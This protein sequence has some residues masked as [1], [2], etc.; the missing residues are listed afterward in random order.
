LRNLLKLLLIESIC[1]LITSRCRYR[2]NTCIYYRCSTTVIVSHLRRCWIY[3]SS[4]TLIVEVLSLLELIPRLIK[5]RLIWL[6]LLRLVL[7]RWLLTSCIL[8]ILSLS[9]ISIIS[10]ILLLAIVSLII[11]IILILLCLFSHISNIL[12]N[13]NSIYYISIWSITAVWLILRKLIWIWGNLH[14]RSIRRNSCDIWI[15][16]YESLS[17]HLLLRGSGY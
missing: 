12:M 1:L 11:T 3:Q 2:L 17:Y 14:L 6:I 15:F 4:G 9:L 13:V 7:L 10:L 16:W 8:L 5:L